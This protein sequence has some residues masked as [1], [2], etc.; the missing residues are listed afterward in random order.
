M[1]TTINE[2][3]STLRSTEKMASAFVGSIQEKIGQDVSEQLIL[4][5]LKKFNPRSIE[6]G[7]VV[8]AVKQEMTRQNNRSRRRGN[9]AKVMPIDPNQAMPT[10]SSARQATPSGRSRVTAS[11]TTV[12]QLEDLL[13]SNWNR[14]ER[15]GFQP[16]RMNG[17]AFISAVHRYS[18]PRDATRVRIVRACEV[19]DRQD[20]LITPT[21]V[22]DVIRG[23]A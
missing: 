19:V 6:I 7:R 10:S 17:P 3:A 21:A 16:E 1:E 18:D 15:E 12:E 20:V 8:V 22:A 4:T 23:E 13:T 14:A 2:I 9:G 5:V 11:K